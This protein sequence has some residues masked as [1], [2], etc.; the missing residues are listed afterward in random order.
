MQVHIQIINMKKII[1]E[2]IK[3]YSIYLNI[4]WV[5]NLIVQ[6]Q[7][8]LLIMLIVV[9]RGEVCGKTAILGFYLLEVYKDNFNFL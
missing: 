4:S 8:V 5:L 6:W 9:F 1:K 7:L 2:K 3:K